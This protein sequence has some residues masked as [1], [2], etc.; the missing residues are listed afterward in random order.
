MTKATTTLYQSSPPKLEAGTHEIKIVQRVTIDRQE[1]SKGDGDF[2]CTL[3]VTV[4]G[5]GHRLDPAL[6][7]NLYPPLGAEGGFASALPHISLREAVWP[8]L[9]SAGTVG[10]VRLP[11]V[12]LLVVYDSDRDVVWSKP[13]GGGE[14]VTLPG[15]L[16]KKI[17]PNAT[18]LQAL[19]HVQE[20]TAPIHP[21]KGNEPPPQRFSVI[22]SKRLAPESGPATACLVSLAGKGRLLGTAPA[23]G[24]ALPVLH[25][26]SFKSKPGAGQH[27]QDFKSVAG[28]IALRR[29]CTAE[30]PDPVKVGLAAAGYVALPHRLRDGSL[31]TS[32]YRGPLIPVRPRGEFQRR[33]MLAMPSA[34]ALLACDPAGKRL[35]A[36]YAAAWQLGRLL[37]LSDAEAAQA[38]H[39]WKTGQRGPATAFTPPVNAGA[40]TGTF[41]QAL[42]AVAVLYGKMAEPGALLRPEDSDDREVLREFLTRLYQLEGIPTGYMVPS[43]DLLPVESAAFFHIDPAWTA[44]LADGA[45]AIGGSGPVD[46]GLDI[47]EE[48]KRRDLL[49]AE[50]VPNPP[51]AGFVLRSKLLSLYPGLQVMPLV[52]T[53]NGAAAPGKWLRLVRPAPDLMIGLGSGHLKGA[54]IEEPAEAQSF[55]VEPRPGAGTV[56]ATGSNSIVF[57]DKHRKRRRFIEFPIA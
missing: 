26:W 27:H 7:Q 25:A 39:R 28:A 19:I 21:G 43:Q 14:T 12:A 11:W 6:I 41:P 24:V 31:L 15:E 38:I 52:E 46:G 48:K 57:A 54:R 36:G 55:T 40:E 42:A 13:G 51:T 9:V 4:D 34:D 5:P 33:H 3:T 32:W 2:S 49:I 16:F 47:D 23:E 30:D 17:V 29:L 20:V 10:T 50:I 44:A 35:V 22:V 8:W 45:L 56:T 37:A 53:A 1:V 18:E